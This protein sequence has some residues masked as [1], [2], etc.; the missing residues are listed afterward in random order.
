MAQALLQRRQLG[1]LALLRNSD[2]Q[3]RA[4]RGLECGWRVGGSW[5]GSW[6]LRESVAPEALSLPLSH[7]RLRINKHPALR[8]KE[9]LRHAFES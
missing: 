8:R 6:K 5:R 4:E 9:R 3:A 1:D 7:A 2:T